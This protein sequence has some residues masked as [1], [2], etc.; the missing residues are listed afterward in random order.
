VVDKIEK[1]K[2]DIKITLGRS[3]VI[4]GRKNTIPKK[5]GSAFVASQQDVYIHAAPW[6]AATTICC[7]L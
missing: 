5:K 6:A 2:M 1:F 3:R 7:G 4:H